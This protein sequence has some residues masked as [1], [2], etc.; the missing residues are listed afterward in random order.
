SGRH[1]DQL[2]FE[3]QERIAPLLGFT[4]T[5]TTDAS[6]S[7]SSALMRFYYAQAAAIHR[8]S[9]GL[10]ARV[11][12]DPAVGRFMRRTGGR[13]IR[14]G[15]LI[16]GRLLAIAEKE[17]FTRAPIN[18]LTIFADC[19]AHGVELSGSAYQQVRDSLRS[20]ERRVGKEWRSR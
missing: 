3:Y 15:V 12:D 6:G 9:E 14:P 20:E 2:T 18:L 19:Q 1:F 8:F 17:F 5:T 4:D 7:A 11:T 16:Q 10:I 13:Q